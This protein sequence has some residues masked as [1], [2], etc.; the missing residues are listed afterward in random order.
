MTDNEMD[1]LP[2]HIQS[3][4]RSSF[5]FCGDRERNAWRFTS[6]EHAEAT[7]K[8]GMEI[9]PCSACLRAA[10]REDLAAKVEGVTNG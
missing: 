8:N 1:D 4:D 2:Q 9:V 3:G 7:I 10:G 5:S 6:V